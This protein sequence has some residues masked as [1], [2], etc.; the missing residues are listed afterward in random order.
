MNAAWDSYS[1]K[2]TCSR[3]FQIYEQNPENEQPAAC[4][5][6]KTPSTSEKRLMIG[7][8]LSQNFSEKPMWYIYIYIHDIYIYT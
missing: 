1:T 5:C 7:M 3:R 6:K 8:G 4:S 2:K